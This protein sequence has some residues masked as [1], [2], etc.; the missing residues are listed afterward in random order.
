M[1]TSGLMDKAHAPTISDSSDV[2]RHPNLMIT[3]LISSDNQTDRVLIIFVYKYI[4][5]D[6]LA[7]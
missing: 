3:L 4:D 2:K 1:L 7:A 6:V 5:D